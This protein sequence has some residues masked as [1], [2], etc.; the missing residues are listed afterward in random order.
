MGSM[1]G[2]F[3]ILTD[4]TTEGVI[5]ISLVTLVLGVLLQ[6]SLLNRIE[7]M[8]LP[9]G[10]IVILGVITFLVG[11]D[12]I[13]NIVHSNIRISGEIYTP[14][15]VDLIGSIGFLFIAIF[16]IYKIVSLIRSPE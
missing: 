4:Q 11:I 15:L 7:G 5:W 8:S 2:L 13:I 1:S 10:S 9:I 6:G 14:S 16:V 12:E 3:A